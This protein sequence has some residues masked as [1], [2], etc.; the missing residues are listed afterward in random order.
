VKPAVA[1]AQPRLRVFAGPNGSGKS[2]IHEILRPEWIGVYVNADE[3]EKQLR[4]SGALDLNSFELVE[5]AEALQRRISGHLAASEL[6][7]RHGLLQVAQDVAVTIDRRLHLPQEVASS[8]VA[9]VLAD[10]IRRALLAQGSTFTF[11]T[12]M[13][14]RDRSTSCAR[15]RRWATEPT[16]TSWPRTTLRST[17]RV[18]NCG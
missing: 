12:V 10:A 5:P 17:S 16:C 8:Y 14:S 15:L 13:S 18:C 3:I 9:A 11:E 6:L 1:S 4:H 2:T 7:A